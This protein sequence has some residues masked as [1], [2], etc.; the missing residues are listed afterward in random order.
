MYFQDA[1]AVIIRVAGGVCKCC[2]YQGGGWSCSPSDLL[3]V[4]RLEG[5]DDD[6][7]EALASESETVAVAVAVHPPPGLIGS[8]FGPCLCLMRGLG[9]ALVSAGE[10]WGRTA[11]LI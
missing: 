10:C 11:R 4:L 5:D 9:R 1:N 3:L 7:D 8:V 2:D 6:D